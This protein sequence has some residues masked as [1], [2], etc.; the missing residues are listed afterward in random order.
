MKSLLLLIILMTITVSV[1]VSFAWSEDDVE[2]V[3]NEGSPL[4]FQCR[5][6]KMCKCNQKEVMGA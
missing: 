1:G 5:M 6:V 2:A 4:R 3:A